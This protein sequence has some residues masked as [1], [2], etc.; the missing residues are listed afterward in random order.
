MINR[1][2][3][4]KSIA[5]VESHDQALVGDKTIAQWLFNE[6]IY[7][8]MS[9]LS[10]RTVTIER[11][12]AL[13]KMIRLLT[14]ALGG[15]A[16]L[17]FEGRNSSIDTRKEI[18]FVIGNEFGH[19]EWLDFPRLGN[20]ESYKYARRLFHLSD[21]STLRYQYLNAWDKSMNELEEHYQ[22]LSASNIVRRNQFV[23][24]LSNDIFIPVVISN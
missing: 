21:D 7:S 10:P 17:N 13:H 20:N 8:H 6:Q 15:E 3:S 24:L 16:W 5:Y 23:F 2:S 14:Y 4:E 18:L 19:P 12:L 9:V 22:W 1:R 11:G